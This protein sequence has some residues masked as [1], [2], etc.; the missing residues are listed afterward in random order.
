MELGVACSQS[1]DVE[2]ISETATVSFQFSPLIVQQQKSICL[3]LNIVHVVKEQN[4]PNEMVIEMAEPCE[5]KGI[6]GDGNC[7]FRA[8]AYSVSGS[9]QEHRN[10]GGP[11]FHIF[12]KMKECMYNFLDKDYSSVAEY[13]ATSRMKFVGTWATEMEIQ[14]ASD[15]IG[16]GHF[17]I[18]SREM[19]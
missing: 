2:F 14:A 17:Y 9:Q 3:K 4:N 11:S 19:A 18:Q 7:F 10:S 16:C 1:S 8:L 12:S 15:L 5:T 13:I 6:I